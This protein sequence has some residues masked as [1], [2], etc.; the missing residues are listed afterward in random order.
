MVSRKSW[1]EVEIGH[2]RE[3]LHGVGSLEFFSMQL[4][5][6]VRQL[7]RHVLAC[8]ALALAVAALSPMVHPNATTLVC[9]AGGAKWVTVDDASTDHNSHTLDCPL[10]LGVTAPPPHVNLALTQPAP[11]L[12]VVRLGLFAHWALAVAPPMPSRG[13]PAA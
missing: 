10:C 9:G 13:P 6:N 8:F 5:F 12:T 2:C 1:N 3:G 11:M 7:A 4:F